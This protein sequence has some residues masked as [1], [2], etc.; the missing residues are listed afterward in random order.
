MKVA[1]GGR[2]ER[3]SSPPL[4]GELVSAGHEVA[5]LSPPRSGRVNGHIGESSLASNGGGPLRRRPTAA[6]PVSIHHQR[7][8][9]AVYARRPTRV[10]V[11]AE[12][13]EDRGLGLQVAAGKSHHP[14][15]CQALGFRVPGPGA[16]YHASLPASLPVTLPADA[17]IT[18]T[19]IVWTLR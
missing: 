6:W 11:R 12:A 18:M 15:A 9:V 1:H 8:D 7:D 17:P 3:R 2:G 16:S 5:R 13:P 19:T 10:V 4:P 14:S